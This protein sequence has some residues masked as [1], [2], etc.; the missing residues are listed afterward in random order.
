MGTMFRLRE[1]IIAILPLSGQRGTLVPVP[2]EAIL[3]IAG[4]PQK[5]GLVDLLWEGKRIAAF[6][7]DLESRGEPI[8]ICKAG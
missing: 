1:P 3:E 7:Q 6:L 4:E 5:S 8:N 2:R